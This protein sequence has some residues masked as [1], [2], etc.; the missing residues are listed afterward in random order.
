[1]MINSQGGIPP[2]MARATQKTGST[3]LYSVTNQG[4]SSRPQTSGNYCNNHYYGGIGGPAGATLDP[5]ADFSSN[6]KDEALSFY[7]VLML[8]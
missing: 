7:Q 1:M 5:T 2:M 4:E 6:G 3:N 8:I